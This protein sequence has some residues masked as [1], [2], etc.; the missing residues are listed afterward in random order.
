[1]GK[2]KTTNKLKKIKTQQK[3]KN[4]T[5]RKNKD[6]PETQLTS[7]SKK[8]NTNVFTRLAF[9]LCL[10]LLLSIPSSSGSLRLKSLKKINKYF[11]T[12]FFF[13]AFATVNSYQDTGFF[14]DTHLIPCCLAP[15]SI[16]KGSNLG[17]VSFEQFH[18]CRVGILLTVSSG[19]YNY[20][21]IL[22]KHQS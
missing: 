5:H 13:I 22:Y 3:P 19:M 6:I 7:L 10:P 14:T 15:H 9:G 16:L 1:M 17:Q 8:K 21:K 18:I 11:G 12:S 20:N 4:K 2:R